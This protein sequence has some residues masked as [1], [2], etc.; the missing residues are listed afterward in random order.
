MST[1]D[2][3]LGVANTLQ[4]ERK[5]PQKLLTQVQFIVT[6]TL[7]PNQNEKIILTSLCLIFNVFSVFG[8][9]ND[10]KYAKEVKSI[11]AIINAY[12]DVVSGSSVEPWKF[13]KD[14]FIHL[15]NTV[16]TRLDKNGKAEY[17]LVGLSPKEDSYEKG[18]KKLVSDYGNIA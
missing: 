17:I 2:I 18:L 6:Q 5:L 12:Y 11:D 9:T 16:I 15:K 13:E 14:T 3:F 8:Q 4:T 10:R 1:K 7:K